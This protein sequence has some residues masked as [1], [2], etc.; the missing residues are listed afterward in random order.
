M[1]EL[2]VKD[3]MTRGVVTVEEDAS[4]KQAVEILADIFP[5]FW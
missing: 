4:V 3:V 1:Q 5:D 2:K